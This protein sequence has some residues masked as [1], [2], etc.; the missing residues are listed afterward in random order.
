MSEYIVIVD[1]VIKPQHLADFMP[2][3]LGNAQASL[4]DEPGCSQFDVC[5]NPEQQTHVFLYEVYDDQA[6]FKAHLLTSHFAQFDRLTT[7]WIQSK[8]V[9][10]LARQG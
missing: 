6:A 5:V 10:I 2:A 1:F 4:R 8:A 7:D 9:R 3:M